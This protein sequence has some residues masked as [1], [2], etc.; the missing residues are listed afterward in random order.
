MFEQQKLLQLE[1]EDAI[2]PV[3]MKYFPQ[4]AM[5]KD[6]YPEIYRLRETIDNFKLNEPEPPI[7]FFLDDI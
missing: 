2:V 5:G 3:L 7:G 6:T 4:N 1:I